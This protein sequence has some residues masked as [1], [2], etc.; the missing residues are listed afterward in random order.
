VQDREVKMVSEL[1]GWCEFDLTLREVCGVAIESSAD[2]GSILWLP[3]SWCKA[4]A[5][6]YQ[7]LIDDE[8]RRAK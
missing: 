1:V 7:Q 2:H 3:F 6:N 5:L 8:L 4:S